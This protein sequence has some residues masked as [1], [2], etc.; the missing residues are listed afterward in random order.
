MRHQDHVLARISEAFQESTTEADARRALE[1]LRQRVQ[2]SGDL[3]AS[4]KGQAALAIIAEVE[5]S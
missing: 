5:K 2:Q 1:R 3:S 4:P